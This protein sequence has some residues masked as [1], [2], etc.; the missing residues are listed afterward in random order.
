MSGYSVTRLVRGKPSGEGQIAWN[1]LQPLAPESVA[2]FEA[3]IHLAGESVVGRWT[4]A[5][6]RRILESREL[7]TRHLA[8]SLAKTSKRPR[9]LISASASGYYGNRNDEI[10]RET[11]S[12]GNEI[13][14]ASCRERV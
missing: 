2:G 8:E 11:S 13:G 6:K 14:R 12:S 9:V 4:E 10:L 3:V 5:K 1:P 7:G